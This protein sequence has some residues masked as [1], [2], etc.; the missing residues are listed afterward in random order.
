MPENA[1]RHQAL[2]H[3]SPRNKSFSPLYA[4][5]NKDTQRMNWHTHGVA[6]DEA[7]VLFDV[8]TS[9]PA[10]RWVHMVWRHNGEKWE[11]YGN[12]ERLICHAGAAETV[13]DSR[14]MGVQKR[15]EMRH[16]SMPR[17][18]LPKNGLRRPEHEV[19]ACLRVARLAFFAAVDPIG[20]CAT[21]SRA[22]FPRPGAGV[23]RC[24]VQAAR[25][26]EFAGVAAA[27]FSMLLMVRTLTMVLSPF[28]CSR[29]MATS[30]TDWP[31]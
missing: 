26:L 29:A 4:Y 20:R 21:S 8:P 10:R 5:F 17:F 30:L 14:L 9:L 19:A 18:E 15:M 27:I 13:T 6:P 2:F 7:P 24:R 12:G 23:V 3:L 22:D 25:W 16:A 11:I 1:R 31:T 28:F